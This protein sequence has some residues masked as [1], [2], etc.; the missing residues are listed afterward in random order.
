MESIGSMQDCFLVREAQGGNHAAFEQLVHA[1][2]RAVLRLALRITGSQS[3]AQDIYQEVFLK[4][5]NNIG[6]FRFECSFKTWVCRIVTH[7]CLDHLRKN[8][9]DREKSA[10]FDGEEYDLLNQISDDRPV[11]NPEQQL[12]SRELREHIL[13]ALQNLNPRERMV[14]ELVHFQGLKV[15]T[16]S[17]VLDSSKASVKSSLFRATQKMRLQLAFVTKET[18]ASI[19]RDCDTRGVN[20]AAILRKRAAYDN[21]HLGGNFEHFD[22]RTASG[23]EHSLIAD[24]PP[25]LWL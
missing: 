8:R 20:Q 25:I 1:H 10:K 6:G 4:V 13:C 7:A 24:V 5:Y 2:D 3:D 16:V 19:K 22:V 14:F 15:R 21:H 17:E 9:K 12:L 23:P 18:K 11:N